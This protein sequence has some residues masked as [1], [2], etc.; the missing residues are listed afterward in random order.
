MSLQSLE[1][2]DFEMPDNP[3][4]VLPA[5]APRW[6]VQK[7][8]QQLYEGY[9]RANLDL[10]SRGGTSLSTGHTHHKVAC[11]RDPRLRTGGTQT[12]QRSDEWLAELRSRQ[13][14]NGRESVVTTAVNSDLHRALRRNSVGDDIYRVAA[15]LYPICRSITGNGVRETLRRLQPLL[16]LTVYEVPSGTA[17][18]DWT[19]PR[20]WD[21][22]AAFIDIRTVRPS[23]ILPVTPCTWSATACRCTSACHSPSSSAT[24]IRCPTNLT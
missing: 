23:S 3:S 19:V 7:G 9:L 10:E 17:V 14:V 12:P 21:I 8:A 11:R 16:P 5:F 15:D 2:C 22:R 20:E 1:T 4:R 18:F 6:D 24:S 13:W